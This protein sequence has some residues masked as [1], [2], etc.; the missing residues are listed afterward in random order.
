L[1]LPEPSDYE[2]WIPYSELEVSALEQEVYQGNVSD[3]LSSHGIDLCFGL[4]DGVDCTHCF[5]YHGNAEFGKYIK[6]L[7]SH[8]KADPLGKVPK[9]EAFMDPSQLSKKQL[10]ELAQHVIDTVV[11]HPEILQ[12]RSKNLDFL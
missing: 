11:A 12:P 2:W 9:Q 5:R 7:G 8:L 1:I 4:R 6:K 10:E 3:L